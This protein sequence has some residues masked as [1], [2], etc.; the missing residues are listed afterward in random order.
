[1]KACTTIYRLTHSTT[2]KHTNI[3]K[4][5]VPAMGVADGSNFMHEEDEGK[6]ALG[7]TKTKAEG[8]RK[9]QRNLNT[10]R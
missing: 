7:Q 9:L 4:Q 5:S 1:M 2:D 6:E 3:H 10:V 8:M